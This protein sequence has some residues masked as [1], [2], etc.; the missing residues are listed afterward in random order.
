MPQ[1]AT[2][3]YSWVN[4][5]TFP[6]VDP[7]YYQLLV[8]ATLL[9]WGISFLGFSVPI[10]HIL[11]AFTTSV[12]TQ[13]LF[14]RYLKLSPNLLSTFNSTLSIILLLHASSWVW[15]ALAS[16]IAISSKFVIRFNNKHIF[17]PSNIGIVAVLLL[18]SSAWAAPGQ[19]GQ[20]LWLA[21]LLAG[22]GLILFIGLSRLLTSISFLFVFSSLILLR[23]LW[24]GDPLQI[25]LHQLQNGALLI[26]TFFMLSDPM[27]SPNTPLARIIF[28]AWIGVLSWILQFVF[29]IPNAFLYALATSMPLVILLNHFFSNKYA[30]ENLFRWSK[31]STRRTQ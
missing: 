28:G 13:L 4:Q 11:A 21:L 23:A 15:I 20:L 24:L 30:K 16:F 19:W 3:N 31:H 14:T 22:S 5:S 1:T 27:T 25:P 7:R 18:T 17:N 12:F 9:I 10:S 2:T 8:Q 29:Y 26:F 6:S